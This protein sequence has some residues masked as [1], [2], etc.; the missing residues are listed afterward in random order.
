MSDELHQPPLWL[1][2]DRVALGPFSRDL[3]ER[4]W[5]WEQEPESLVGYGRQTPESL[6]ARMAGYESSAWHG[7]PAALHGV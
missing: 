7:Q 3:V 2:G 4:Y 1:R 6:G 5:R